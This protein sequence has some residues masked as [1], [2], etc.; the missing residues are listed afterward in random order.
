MRRLVGSRKGIFG[1]AAQVVCVPQWVRRF[2]VFPSSQLHAAFIGTLHLRG[3]DWFLADFLFRSH[4][5]TCPVVY[6]PVHRWP[7]FFVFLFLSSTEVEGQEGCGPCGVPAPPAGFLASG[8]GEAVAAMTPACCSGCTS[9]P[10]LRCCP[11]LQIGVEEPP[12]AKGRQKRNC[13]ILERA[14]C[15][16]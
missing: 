1:S 15:R 4:E 3:L 10:L 7:F 14:G 9:P 6:R 12:L 5:M 16:L 8:V 2:L 11:E 13:R